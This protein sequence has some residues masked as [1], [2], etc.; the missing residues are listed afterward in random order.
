MR[1]QKEFNKHELGERLTFR[2]MILA[3]CYE[4]MGKYADGKADC[5]IPVCPLYP[6]MP[7][8][9]MAGKYKVRK[10][11]SKPSVGPKKGRINGPSD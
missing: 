4:C 3:K 5:S 7:Y 10:R 6:M 9:T 1:G 8:G 2:Q 11:P